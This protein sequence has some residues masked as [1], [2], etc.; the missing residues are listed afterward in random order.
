MTISVFTTLLSLLTLAQAH[1]IVALVDNAVVNDIIGNKNEVMVK[2]VTL[3]E[4]VRDY[5]ADTP[6]LAE[7][8]MCESTFRHIGDDGT[9]LRGKRNKADVGVMQINEYY[10]AERADRLN[11]DLYT[12]DGNLAYAKYLY[13]R[14]G[15]TPWKASAPCWSKMMQTAKISGPAKKV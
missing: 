11:Y 9:V 1:I 10:H 3:E 6:V 4:F 5:F 14:Y 13:E 8:A 15:L 2:P 12:L 7:V